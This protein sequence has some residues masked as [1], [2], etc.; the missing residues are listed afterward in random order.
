MNLSCALR[1]RHSGF[2]YDGITPIRTPYIAVSVDGGLWSTQ[3]KTHFISVCG[4]HSIQTTF[5][6][7]EKYDC[8]FQIQP[9]DILSCIA[10]FEKLK[11]D[12]PLLILDHMKKKVLSVPIE[13]VAAKI[14]PLWSKLRDFQKTCVHFG[15]ARERVYIGDA[16]GSGKTLQAIAT[17]KYFEDDWP[18]LI[19]CPSILRNT[20]KNELQKWI[21]AAE[22]DIYIVH[23]S[24]SLKKVT[25]AHK[26]LIVSYSLIAKTVVE[27]YLKKTNYQVVILDEAHYIK[28]PKS[29]RSKAAIRIV[30]TSKIRI[31]L[32]GTPFSYP[33]EMY[34]Q[35][36]ALHPCIYPGYFNYRLGRPKPG[37][38]LMFANRY[39]HPEKKWQGRISRWSLQ[40]YDRSEELNAVLSTFMIRRRKETIL[41]HLPKKVRSCM[42]LDPLKKKEYS[43]ISELLKSEKSESRTSFMASFRLTCKYKIPHVLKFIKK[44]I[45][46]DL[47]K[48]DPSLCVLIFSHH[49]LMREAVEDLLTKEKSVPFFSIYGGVSNEKRGE[50][51]HDFQNTSKYRCGVLSIQAACTGLTLTRASV[52]VF[53]ELLFGP[54][55]MFQAEDRVH[56]ISQTSNVN[57]FYLISPKTTDD[58]N[59]GL[60]KKKERESSNILD[61]EVNHVVSQRL[62]MSECGADTL[63]LLVEKQT[64]TSGYASGTNRKRKSSNSNS[65]SNSGRIVT[66]RIVTKRMKK[67]LNL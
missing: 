3:Q 4:K 65:N 9:C 34:Q 10:I 52:V 15:V 61:G 20:W 16:M 57:I 56:R 67:I 51:E 66:K 24:K 19:V 37:E 18:V 46:D 40:G 6:E 42:V 55:I 11:N 21:G 2:E 44:Y 12:I 28:S 58:I 1:V 30:D 33:C 23:S 54:D 17:C 53:T 47:L 41:P 38:K 39:C 60:I 63:D 43:E 49:K 8:H 64:T 48:A 13:S 7:T 35:I 14:G 62:N 45:V 25:P 59:W 32:S 29:K 27:A 5:S 26:F 22:E 36:K 31:L 50:F